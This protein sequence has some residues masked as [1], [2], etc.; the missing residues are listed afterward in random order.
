MKKL[1][2][3]G[4]L[5]LSA[6]LSAQ[7]QTIPAGT[8][9]TI[10]MIDS[11]DSSKNS[12]GQTFHASL[13]SDLVVSGTTVARRGDEAI[14]RL[15]QLE[16]SGK[17]KGR[18]EVGLQLTEIHSNGKIIRLDTDDVVQTSGSKG[19][20]TAV[21]GGI[22]AAAGSIIGAIAG[23]GKG[24]AIGAAAGAGAGAGSQIFTKGETVKVPSETRLTF[25]VSR[26]T[27][28]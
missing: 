18:T 3:V 19:K 5:A 23:G 25:R 6:L 27:D 12:S 13:D 24:A 15:A 14:V 22:G 20:K 16:Q 21:R 8:D 2:G 17:F 9:V 7:A 4:L 1:L 28:I 10:R 26:S 11:V